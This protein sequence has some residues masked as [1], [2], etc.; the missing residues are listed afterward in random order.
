MANQRLEDILAKFGPEYA[1][2][3]LEVLPFLET[4]LLNYTTAQKGEFQAYAICP[5]CHLHFSAI[6]F[7]RANAS[8][9]GLIRRDEYELAELRECKNCGATVAHVHQTFKQRPAAGVRVIR[10]TNNKTPCVHC[11]G[12]VEPGV[13]TAVVKAKDG[14]V[15]LGSLCP[16]CEGAK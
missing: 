14:E 7:G 12:W 5:R 4:A 8:W 9:E 16:E 10:V 15:K 13:V 6:A 1:E 3:P 11:R 2:R